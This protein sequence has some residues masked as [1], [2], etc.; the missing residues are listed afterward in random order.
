MIE[1]LLDTNIVIYTM[2]N[3]PPE[4]RERFTRSYGLMAIS[5]VTLME[6][7]Y[8]SENSQDPTGNRTDIEGFIARL[9]LLEY[10]APAAFHTGLLRKELQTQGLP[11]GA[12]DCMI[13]GHARSRG[14]ILVTR[15][16]SEFSR[17][18]GLRVEAWT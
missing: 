5:T 4:I 3:R 9:E 15:N 12:Y 7:Y 16:E 10:D 1:Y 6:L 17:V 11:I 2:H 14:L 8:G 18:P 13:A